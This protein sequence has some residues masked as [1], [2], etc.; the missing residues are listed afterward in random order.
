MSLPLAA[1]VIYQTLVVTINAAKGLSD[2]V[3]SILTGEGIL[4]V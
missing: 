3:M 1:L 4:E 2:R